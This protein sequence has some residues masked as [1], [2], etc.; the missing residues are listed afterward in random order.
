MAMRALP[1]QLRSNIRALYQDVFWFGI[2]AGSAMAF[3]IIYATRLGA[4]A[5]Q[6]S[7][8][9]AGPAV[10]NLLFSLPAGKWL[11]GQALIPVTFWSAVLHRLGYL[12][13]IPLP[14]LAGDEIQIW[15]IVLITLLMSIPGTTLAIAFNALFADLIPSEWRSEVVGKR[16]AIV[17]VSLTASTLISG[18]LLDRLVYPLNYQVVFA[19]G[20]LGAALST[21]Y[22]S[23]LYQASSQ[24]AT[25]LPANLEKV[26]IPQDEI[27]ALPKRSASKI[28]WSSIKNL[29]HLLHLD[30]LRSS[31][32]PFMLAYLFFYTFQYLGIPLFPL[33]QVRV[34]ELSDSA[35]SLGSA[36]FYG[37]MFL[38]SLRIVDIS[39]RLGHKRTLAS[40]ATVFAVYP[41][42][43]GLANGPAL[44]WAASFMGGGAWAITNA[45]LINRLM[46]KVPDNQRPAGMSLH[47]L[48]LNLGI[49]AG[50][51][52]APLLGNWSGLQ[53]ALLIIAALRLFAGFI[54]WVRG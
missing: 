34:L 37:V 15:V 22:L 51:L 3:V 50:S 41:L 16:N 29:P 6:I 7:L 1:P 47:N 36:L 17:A 9:T 27:I 21:Y 31:F 2:L 44:F 25:I 32:G 43:L 46:E 5:F 10:V 45:G 23:R 52:A 14:W 28:R 35:I 4:S 24:G 39:A 33:V 18:Q 8:L 13:L 42:L 53:E 54:F 20:A 40:G 11:E 19:I 38:V 48:A 26:T 12:L 30:L 49:L